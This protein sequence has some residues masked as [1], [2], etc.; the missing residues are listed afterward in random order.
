MKSRLLV[1]IAVAAATYTAQA[2]ITLTGLA[3]GTAY[4]ASPATARLGLIVV[5]S[6]VGGDV[7]LGGKTGNG[8]TEATPT[9]TEAAAGLT[10]SSTFFGNTV[11]GV[12]ASSGT[13]MNGANSAILAANAGKQFAIIWT[14]IASAG[15]PANLPGGSTYGFTRDSTWTLGADGTT[16][17][18]GTA[19][20]ASN[21]FSRITNNQTGN[22]TSSFGTVALASQGLAFAVVPEPSAALL[23]AIGALGLLRRR[24]N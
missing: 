4:P 12:V 14:S 23:G 24:R 19:V 8:L 1:L 3:V 16:L 20:S 5:G 9:L 6:G 17:G 22:S 13:F 21:P 15:A 18:F 10:V 7:F 2:T 11:V